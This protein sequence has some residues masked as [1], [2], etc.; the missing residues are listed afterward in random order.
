LA[1][2]GNAST[3]TSLQATAGGDAGGEAEED[4]GPL[5]QAAATT[6]STGERRVLPGEGHGL[7]GR[8]HLAGA[9]EGRGRRPREKKEKPE[10]H[11]APRAGRLKLITVAAVCRDA[12]GSGRGSVDRTGASTGATRARRD[13]HEESAPIELICLPD[14]PGASAEASL[15]RMAREAIGKARTRS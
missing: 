10:D 6:R 11:G 7:A 15:V 2:S 8:E 1:R 14:D 9:G 13:Q 3:G 12:N 5:A 4:E